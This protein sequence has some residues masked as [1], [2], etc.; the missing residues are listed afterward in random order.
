M[1]KHTQF[2]NGKTV[3][4][5]VVPDELEKQALELA[6]DCIMS[7]RKTVEG[8]LNHLFIS[9]ISKLMYRKFFALVTFFI[10]DRL[11]G[12]SAKDVPH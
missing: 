7:I 6:Y 4:Q 5:V 12:S 2:N 8:I 11:K 9:Q 3:R 10:L 1:L